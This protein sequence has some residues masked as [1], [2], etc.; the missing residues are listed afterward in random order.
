MASEAV[1]NVAKTSATVREKTN[2]F[3]EAKDVFNHR[4]EIF[5]GNDD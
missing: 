3:G 1:V 5:N 4:D 2:I